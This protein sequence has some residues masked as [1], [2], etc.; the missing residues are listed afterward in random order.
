MNKIITHNKMKIENAFKN[1]RAMKALTGLT[2]SE[3]NQLL[4]QFKRIF[5]EHV[6]AKKRQRKYGGGQKGALKSIEGKLFFMLFYLKVYPTFDLAGFIFGVDRSRPCEW[7]GVFLPLLEKTLGRECVLPKRKI[8]NMEEFLQAFPEVSDFFEDG[9]ERPTRRPKNPKNQKRQ[10]SGKKKRHTRKNTIWCKESQE[11][12]LVSPS[13]NGRVHDKK[14][15]DKNMAY[16]GIPPDVHVWVDSG[17]QGVHKQGENVHIPKKGTKKKP[18]TDD[19]KKENRVISHF[20]IVV[21]N[22]IAGIKRYGCVS[23]IY[24]NFNGID[25]TFMVVCSALWNFHLKYQ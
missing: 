9:T 18:L 7:K 5:L 19:E 11:I 12:M 10:Y 16:R 21:E 3:F 15:H 13:K 4:I 8:H 23:N 1:D 20:R 25:D 24:R 14:Q 17:Y 6:N 22:A 2:R